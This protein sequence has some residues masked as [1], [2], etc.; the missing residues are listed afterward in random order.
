[1][2][3][4]LGSPFRFIFCIGLAFCAESGF[5][6]GTIDYAT[7]R[8][9]RALSISATE[10]LKYPDKA[11][12]FSNERR[13]KLVRPLVK[14]EALPATLVF[15]TNKRTVLRLEGE[16][17]EWGS[18]NSFLSGYD[19]LLHAGVDVVRVLNW[20]HNP[21]DGSLEY[22]EVEQLHGAT[23]QEWLDQRFAGTDW[24][25]KE[26]LE[27]ILKFAR[28]T[29]H[30]SRIGDFALKQVFGSPNGWKL[31]D[32]IN[33][34]TM[35]RSEG[36]DTVFT[37]MR[38]RLERNPR[39]K[40]SKQLLRLVRL[41]EMEVYFARGEARLCGGLIMNSLTTT[42]QGSH[43]FGQSLRDQTDASEPEY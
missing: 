26:E 27:S 39:S 6:A 37:A 29:S 32:W 30:F 34:H 41:M 40:Y 7:L 1:M 12:R 28:S 5:S 31:I 25:T 2:N 21:T 4:C 15:L 18:L 20:G 19:S 17:G 24:L 8:P 9:E 16:R 11:I 14:L 35:V 3:F 43:G 42:F 10:F 33:L 22:I 23:L 13:F 36:E 38:Q